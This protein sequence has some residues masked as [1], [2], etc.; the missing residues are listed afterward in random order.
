MCLCAR[1]CLNRICYTYAY[2]HIGNNGDVGWSELFLSF[3]FPP[4]SL[5]LPLT[6]SIVRRVQDQC[7]SA[8]APQLPLLP[9]FLQERRGVRHTRTHIHTCF[10]ACVFCPK[11]RA[12][13]T[14][15]HA[16]TG[17][18]F[19]GVHTHMYVYLFIYVAH[20]SH[21]YTHNFGR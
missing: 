12:A 3:P 1:A 14:N 16:Q 17:G 8:R 4:P 21:I 5:S 2:L 15:A 13:I 11:Y 6:G 10:G 18:V 7:G 20:T 9:E 19:H